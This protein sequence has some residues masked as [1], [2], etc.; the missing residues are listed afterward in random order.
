MLVTIA[1]TMTM[2]IAWAGGI[3][4]ASRPIDTVGRPSPMCALDEAREQ[5]GGGD[6]EK[7]GIEHGAT[8]TYRHN[9]H[10]LEVTET[11]FG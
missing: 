3:V 2:A 4:T 10:N 11:A 1:G 8:L 5:E 9:G 6:E 7:Q